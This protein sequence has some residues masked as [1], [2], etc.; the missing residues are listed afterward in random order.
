VETSWGST[1]LGVGLPSHKPPIYSPTSSKDVGHL[2]VVAQ[3]QKPLHNGISMYALCL[4][5]PINKVD[6]SN[7]AMTEIHLGEESR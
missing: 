4:R 2:S 5:G 7:I 3:K 6:S 1:G